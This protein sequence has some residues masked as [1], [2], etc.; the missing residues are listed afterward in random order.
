MMRP[1]RSTDIVG[2]TVSSIN[3]DAVNVLK[4]TFTDGTELELWT[5]EAVSGQYGSIAG[6]FVDDPSLVETEEEDE[7]SGGCSGCHCCKGGCGK[8]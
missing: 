1:I 4:L 3:N 8:D 7:G 2:K 6:I 5:E